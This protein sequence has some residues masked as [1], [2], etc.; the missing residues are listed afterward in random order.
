MLDNRGHKLPFEE[1]PIKSP[2]ILPE[3]HP[4]RES[5]SEG[6]FDLVESRFCELWHYRP[7]DETKYLTRPQLDL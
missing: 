3:P 4:D 2:F 7:H 6:D 5:L 1:L